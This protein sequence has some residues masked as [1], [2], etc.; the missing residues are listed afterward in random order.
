MQPYKSIYLPNHPRAMSNGCVYEHILVAEQKLGRILRNNECVHHIDGNTRNNDPNNLMIFD[1]ISSHATFHNGGILVDNNDGTFSSYFEKLLCPKCK[2][3]HKDYDAKL[4]I[5]CYNEER[6]KNIPPKEQLIN[7]FVNNNANKAAVARIYNVTQTTV[8][9]WCK[10]YNIKNCLININ[11]SKP[12][13]E[14][15]VLWR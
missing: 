13:K 9:K 1:S 8:K 14:R 7:N 6:I 4:C 15:E 5:K 10:R 12:T 11:M 2:I 3:N